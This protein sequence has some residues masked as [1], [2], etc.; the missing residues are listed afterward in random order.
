MD[1]TDVHMTTQTLPG[2]DTRLVA[3]ALAATIGL[4]WVMPLASS[5]WLD[6][7]G[8][9]WVIEDDLSTAIERAWTYHGQTPLYYVITWSISQVAGASEAVLRVPSLTATVGAAV[10]TFRIASRHFGRDA[11]F[12]ALATF[13]VLP[14]IVFHASDARPYGMALFSVLLCTTALE[15]WVEKRTFSA[16]AWYGGAAALVVYVHFVSSTILIAHGIFIGYL[17]SRERGDRDRI[18]AWIRQSSVAT[19]VLAVAIAPTLVQVSRLLNRRDELVFTQSPALAQ[20]LDVWVL[21]LAALP[22][23]AVVLW[24]ADRRPAGTTRV[25]RTSVVLMGLGFIIPPVALFALGSA[26]DL[27]LWFPR[28]WLAAVPFGAMLFG[29]AIHSLLYAPRSTTVVVLSIL[30]VG[31]ASEA[32]PGH[33]SEDWRSAATAAESLVESEATP[34][35]VFSNLAEAENPTYLGDP[36]HRAYLLSPISYYGVRGSLQPLAGVRSPEDFELRTVPTL[37]DLADHDT[38]VLIANQRD[39]ELLTSFVSGWFAANNFRLETF[40]SHGEVHVTRFSR[41]WLDD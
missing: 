10:L 16:A 34:V 12:L 15:A 19:S 5:L 29:T 24:T 20:L 9:A 21:P 41:S 35:L 11:A 32:R 39:G 26:T 18:M 38:I 2:A 30:I 25:S 13:V 14:G 37:A 4:L 36:E 17:I 31:M 3:T 23:L 33:F 28:Y 1:R 22:L 7:L 8:T 27:V 6:E 40:S